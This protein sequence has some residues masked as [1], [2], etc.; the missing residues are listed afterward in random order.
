MKKFTAM[1]IFAFVS[2]IF[3]SQA[4]AIEIVPISE[5]KPGMKGYGVTVFQGT[6][7][8]TFQVEVYDMTYGLYFGAS[9]RWPIIWAKMSGGPP[10][11]P[12]EKIGPASGM[13]GSPIF[14]QDGRLIGALSCSPSNMDKDPS[15]GITPAEVMLNGGMSTAGAVSCGG[16]KMIKMPLYI[17]GLDIETFKLEEI[18]CPIDLERFILLPM[19]G[20]GMTADT[21]GDGV[22]STLKPGSAI[23]VYLIRGD[24]DMG[25]TGTLTWIDS[26]GFRAFGHPFLGIAQSNLEVAQAKVVTTVANVWSSYKLAGED[27]GQPFGS[28]QEDRFWGIRGEIGVPADVISTSLVLRDDEKELRKVQCSV[29]RLPDWTFYLLRVIAW[30]MISREFYNQENPPERGSVLIETE[31]TFK[32]GQS[33]KLGQIYGYTR[34]SIYPPMVNFV[35]NYLRNLFKILSENDALSELEEVNF[36]VTFSKEREVLSLGR[37]EFD[38][39]EVCPGET[40]NLAL[41]F[42]SQDSLTTYKTEVPFVVPQ[43]ARIDE[44]VE[45]QVKTGIYFDGT[46]QQID[47]DDDEEEED[48]LLGEKELQILLDELRTWTNISLFVKAKFPG[49][50][51]EEPGPSTFNSIEEKET[52]TTIQVDSTDRV[53]VW[54]ETRREKEPETETPEITVLLEIRPPTVARIEASQVLELTVSNGI[55]IQPQPKKPDDKKGLLV[56]GGMVIVGI[57]MFFAN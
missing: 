2:L 15:C 39:N 38:K 48:D 46:A 52:A 5:I 24:I 41:T 11:Y 1:V 29:A 10:D 25:A 32:T 8:D 43:S 17:S 13:S 19:S 45:V 42:L 14:A 20:G 51:S 56:L 21:D 3:V 26:T 54:K 44:I 37:A 6:E 57:I 28:I 4:N 33:L 22:T 23:T 27:I 47:P 30:N 18:E 40:V 35:D 49:Y 53:L 31:L 9:K 50:L 16:A 36:N 12:T 55:V 34:G 7:P